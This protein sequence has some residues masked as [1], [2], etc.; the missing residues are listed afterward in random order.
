MKTLLLKSATFLKK[1]STST[2][3]ILLFLLALG[4]HSKQIFGLRVTSWDTFDIFTINF[5]YF[6][7]ALKSGDFPLW[8]PF[9]LSGIPFF[10]SVAFSASLFSPINL[11]LLFV[12]LWLNPIWLVEV[13]LLIA[14]CLGGVGAFKFLEIENFQ[15]K[16]LRLLFSFAYMCVLFTPIFGQVYFMYSFAALPWLLFFTKS[17]A[18]NETTIFK[19]VIFGFLISCL[20]ANGYFYF[21]L[22][23]ILISVIY[24]ASDK[25]NFNF[26]P[27]FKFCI[28]VIVGNILFLLLNLEGVI[29]S[30]Q[31]F[32]EYYGDLILKEPRMRALG[33]VGNNFFDDMPGVLITL[34]SDHITKTVS[35]TF[36]LGGFSIFLA[37]LFINIKSIFYRKRLRLILL[38]LALV[39]FGVATSYNNYLF[40]MIFW[41]LPIIKSFRWGVANTFY[42][43]IGLIIISAVSMEPNYRISAFISVILCGFLSYSFVVRDSSFMF[44]KSVYNSIYFK[45]RTTNTE[46]TNNSRELGKSNIYEF[47]NWKWIQNKKPFTHGYNNSTS[48]LY[49]EMKNFLFLEKMFTFTRNVAF[50]KTRARE[51]FQSDQDYIDYKV[52]QVDPNGNKI[53][54][55][56]VD[57]NFDIRTFSE[58]SINSKDNF[59]EKDFKITNNG[60]Y[61]NIDAKE[62]GFFVFFNNWNKNWSAEINGEKAKIFK[63]NLL[64]QAVFLKKGTNRIEFQYTSE[65]FNI[66]I[67]YYLMA[68]ILFIYIFFKKLKY[69]SL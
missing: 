45:N 55:S 11:L 39:I 2:Y 41:K 54:I 65:F 6:S 67:W 13:G 62:S 43:L 27:I 8:N 66:L 34:I 52:G 31:I 3:F 26:K 28:F 60:A 63:A 57:S 36:G 51:S 48:P 32:S 14:T 44:G 20:I 5:M 42:A 64:F 7:D 25:N 9:V 69:L 19:T 4:L 35:W 24:F 17:L 29:H 56:D 21:N 46:I 33:N 18:K 10:G 37:A 53:L 15:N 1:H 61:F 23:N 30:N 38:A 59:V 22:I 49:W 12:S 58:H 40:Q 47:N 16:N 50:E 68:I